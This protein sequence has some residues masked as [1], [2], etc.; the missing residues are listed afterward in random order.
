MAPSLD[1]ANVEFSLGSKRYRIRDGHCCDADG[2]LL[3]LRAQS[4]HVLEY[5]LD[6]NETVVGK[7]I[8]ASVVW[9]NSI[10]SD[11]SISKCISDCRK[12][13][14]DDTHT[15][16]ETFPKR[17]YRINA[18]FHESPPAQWSAEHRPLILA[19]V[20][21]AFTLLVIATFGEKG[22]LTETTVKLTRSDDV[23]GPTEIDKGRNALSSFTYEDNLM[24]ERHFRSAIEQDDE[25]A[26]AYAELVSAIVIRLENNWAVLT[27][28]D[29]ERAFFYAKKAV[30]LNSEL[31]LAH[32]ATGRLY[33]V[34]GSDL[35]KA[36]EHLK[37]AMSL[38]PA[39]DDARVY[40]AAVKIFQGAQEEAIPI[41][42]AALASHPSPPFWYFLGYGHALFQAKRYE[43]AKVPLSRCLSQMPNAPYCLRYQIANFAQLGQ[44]EDAHWAIEEYSALGYSVTASAIME[45]LLDRDSGNREHI[46]SAFKKAGLREYE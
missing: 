30:E 45:V 29:E 21:L 13:L 44:L 27:R 12:V 11:E 33:S 16:L 46:A 9:P 8:L 25:N 2:E 34:T 15:V 3:A 19:G 36:S 18:V 4:A 10:A 26:H 17:G 37:T 41:L 39:S 6:H 23:V 14:G 38:Q 32:Y 42:E 1:K 20:A 43:E 35:T 24:A 7:E 40:F 5:L 22:G 28:A 31:W